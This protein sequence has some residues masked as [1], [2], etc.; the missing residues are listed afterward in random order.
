MSQIKELR[1]NKPLKR[2]K[3]ELE[4]INLKP[5]TEIEIYPI[6]PFDWYAIFGAHN[7]VYI[8]R[9]RRGVLKL[10]NI[11]PVHGFMK[12]GRLILKGDWWR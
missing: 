1:Y 2:I 9:S 10:I 3:S 11:Q 12:N 4:K 7:R 8:F 6:Y 5:E